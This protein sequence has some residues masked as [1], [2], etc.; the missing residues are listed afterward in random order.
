MQATSGPHP[1]QDDRRTL[2]VRVLL[3]PDMLL[4]RNLQTRSPLEKS[5]LSTQKHGTG[6][7]LAQAPGPVKIPQ[8]PRHIRRTVIRRLSRQRHQSPHGPRRD[9]RRQRHRS[10]I[11]GPTFRRPC[12]TSHL[13]RATT[14]LRP[15]SPRTYSPKRLLKHRRDQYPHDPYRLP[16]HS[17]QDQCLRDQLPTLLTH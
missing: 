17:S 7:G 6:C 3:P 12:Q 13:H 14:I 1:Q 4:G 2:H 11:G 9:G 10:G 8:E 16:R 15:E 5:R